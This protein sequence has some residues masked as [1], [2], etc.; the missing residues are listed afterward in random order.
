M[1]G[2]QQQRLQVV[3]KRLDVQLANETQAAALWIEPGT[4][5]QNEA[6]RMC[7][8]YLMSVQMCDELIR[9]VVKEMTK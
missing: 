6:V 9:K 2:Q 7:H 5:P 4:R 1:Q 8:Q 3:R